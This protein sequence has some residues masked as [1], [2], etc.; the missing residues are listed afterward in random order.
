MNATTEKWVYSFAAGSS[1]GN[2]GMKNLLG[3]KGA[4]LAEMSNLGLPVPPGFTI[5]TDLCTHYYDNAETYP[6]T[7]DAQVESALAAIEKDVG[8][9][10]GDAENPL[11]VSV[12]SGARASMPGMMDTVLNLGLNDTTVAGL[13]VRSGDARFAFDS[14]RRFIQMYSD[15]VLGVDHYMFE[16]VLEQHKMDSGLI[17]D[18]DLSAEDWQAIV[19][20]YKAIV[21]R[22][23]GSPFPQDPREQLW[24]AIGAVFGSW[25]NQRAITYRRLQNIP[26]EWGTAVNVQAMVF[27]NMGDD[28][29]TGVAF[30]R[31]PSTGEDIF[32]GEYL[33]N[34]Q[35]EDVVAGIRTPQHLTIAGKK[36]NGSD[37]PSMEEVM[38]EV[39]GQLAEVRGTLEAHYKDMQDIEFT[40]QSNK[41]YMLQTRS[42]KR[43]AAAAVR[44]AVEMVDDGLISQ[45]DAIMRVEAG[46]LDQLLHPRLDPDAPRNVLSKGLPAS[47][48]AAS[49]RIVLSADL[50]EDMAQKGED[51]ILVR[52]ETS[53]EDI[54]GMHAARGIL[55]T[56]GGMTSHAAVVARGMGRPCVAGAGGI[57]VDYAAGQVRVGDRTLE[58]GDRITIDGATGEIIDGEVPTIEPEM[59]GDFAK[60]MTWAD[61][62]RRLK[63]RT[64]AETPIDA[65]TARDFGAEGIGLCRT[66]HMFFDPERIVAVRR[67]ILADDVTGRRAALAELLPFQRQDFVELFNI[68]AG[69]PVTIRLLDPPLHEFL[70]KSEEEIAEVALA[71]GRDPQAMTDRA[72]QLHESNPM[73]GHRGCRL[74]ITYPEIY[75]MQA[76]AIFEAAVI[77][78]KDSDETVLPEIMIPL[79]ATRKEIDIL[80]VCIDQVAEAVFGETGTRVDYQVGTMIELPRAALRAGEIA[81]SAEFFSFGTNDLTQ[82]T[83]G[84][85]RDDASNF[86]TDYEHQGIIDIDPFVSIDVDG[87]G[88]LVSIAAE[89]GRVTRPDIKLGI[90][91][92]HGGDPASVKFCDRTGL[93]YVS[94][95]PYRVPIARLAAAQASVEAGLDT[96]G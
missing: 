50:A 87:V 56:R 63:V 22:E 74:G 28:C 59:S 34:A 88:E 53:P 55:T 43:T 1:D 25:M 2:A 27:G 78:A 82:T 10:F 70:P 71:A 16:E 24:G 54:H 14:Y 65:R 38:P 84:I 85:S 48:G 19:G 17:L 9:L 51:V 42:G 95:S 64:N 67:M 52:I 20:E 66:E 31:D 93:D 37:L 61:S 96:K 72:V 41:L 18:T 92:E 68:M 36:R 35:G 49:G 76:R 79:A 91:G 89:R 62:I 32:Y 57:A 45:S 11:L 21:E 33:V 39:F 83:F 90:C 58:A 44:I 3:G 94:C 60:L 69:L 5:T 86:L 77:V 40:V 46:Q 81:E 26:A 29:A 13:A 75:E 80:K 7:L 4:N 47:P 15:V 30:T 23:L 12:R 8:T 6:D 73:L